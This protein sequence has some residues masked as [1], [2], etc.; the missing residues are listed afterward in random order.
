MKARRGRVAW[1]IGLVMLTLTAGGVTTTA[2]KP[3]VAGAT[4]SLEGTSWQLVR[5]QAGDERTLAPGDRVKYTIAFSAAGRVSMRLDCNRSNGSW[6]SSEIGQLEFG[7]LTTTRALCA[8][9][10]LYDRLIQDME[11]VRSYF[12]KGGRLFLALMGDGGTYEF[13]PLPTTP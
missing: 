3:P 1:A 7:Q 4:T 13:E 2:Q 6:K 5:F 11:Y 8:P 12:F 9:G 10:S